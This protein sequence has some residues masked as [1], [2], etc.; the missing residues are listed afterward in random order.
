MC[1]HQA[2]YAKFTQ[3]GSDRGIVRELAALA[4]ERKNKSSEWQTR[5]CGERYPKSGPS[6]VEFACHDCFVW[7]MWPY[8]LR[9]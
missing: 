7:K 9:T 8:E 2:K 1:D 6:R 5:N 4:E 3:P